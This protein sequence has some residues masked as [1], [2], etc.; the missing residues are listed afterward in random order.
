MTDSVCRKCRSK[1][2]NWEKKTKEDFAEFM[3]GKN[4][5]KIMDEE[6]AEC[7]SQTD[8]VEQTVEI[9]IK[10]TPASHRTCF[11]CQKTDGSSSKVLS[12]EEQKLVFIKRSIVIPPG[13]RCCRDHL[14]GKHL[15]FEALHQIVPT[16]TEPVVINAQGVMN[17]ITECCTIVQDTKHLILMI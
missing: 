4:L 16:K 5:E 11:V 6:I 3:D 7:G 12:A 14:Y 2:D 8:A 9:P 15:T 1:F 13:I 10:R 17:L